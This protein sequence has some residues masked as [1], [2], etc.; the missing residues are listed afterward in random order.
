VTAAHVPHALTVVLHGVL[1]APC[2]MSVAGSL[3]AVA[4]DVTLV[5]PVTADGPVAAALAASGDG[6]LKVEEGGVVKRTVAH[7]VPPDRPLAESTEAL[8][9]AVSTNWTLVVDGGLQLHGPTRLEEVVAALEYGASDSN[10]VALDVVCACVA[11]RD[12]PWC[13]GGGG[14]D[15]QLRVLYESSAL[16][17]YAADDSALAAPSMCA[18]STALAADATVNLLAP[19]RGSGLKD[20]SVAV[21]VCAGWMAASTPPSAECGTR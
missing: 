1:P 6:S 10:S 8:L 16:T 18:M 14:A 9:A 3:A 2:V 11:G 15:S 7:P 4:A 21:A 20:G 19:P 5:V 17:C 13:R 12:N